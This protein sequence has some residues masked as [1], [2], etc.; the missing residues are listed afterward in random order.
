MKKALAVALLP[1]LAACT[2]GPSQAEVKG[3]VVDAST[4][5]PLAGVLVTAGRTEAKTDRRGEFVLPAVKECSEVI[6]TICSHEE[7]VVA[8]LRTIETPV[9]DLGEVELVP[10]RVEVNV[11]SNLTKKGVKARLRGPVRAT[12]RN[13]GRA[14]VLGA[15]SGDRLRVEAPGYEP[16]RVEISEDQAS[17]DV[18]LAADPGTTAGV[19]RRGLV[20]TWRRWIHRTLRHS[21]GP[22][23]G[24]SLAMVRKRQLRVPCSVAASAALIVLA[25]CKGIGPDGPSTPTS[26][27]SPST[28][29]ESPGPQP[30]EVPD[31]VGFVLADAK[32]AA[33]DV[34]MRAVVVEREFSA[35]PMGTVLDQA[36][37]AGSVAEPGAEIGVVISVFPKVPSLVGRST[38]KAKALLSALSLRAGPVV[39]RPS[40]EPKG[41]VL[42]QAI[43]A[44]RRIPAGGR[45]K[46]VAVGPHVC[47]GPLN[48]W[49]YSVAGG[50]SLIYNPSFDLCSWI[51]CISSFW[52]STN[53]Y[54][55]QCADG[56][57]SHSGGVSGSCSYH[58]GNWRPLYAP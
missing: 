40:T 2:S 58:G 27:S 51:D 9:R 31:L 48:P 34:G 56:E 30:E 1:W 42:R 46:L 29:V 39:R 49:C 38:E 25:A 52:S 11:S 4:G 15:C 13:G 10:R 19:C 41:E 16:T 37:A 18:V 17:V 55:I 45:V 32:A 28:S 8:N 47:G 5:E 57:F 20:L 6:A 22:D 7:S 26:S 54:V 23:E 24:W 35:D 43:R 44:G 33:R 12:T 36:T 3:A 14:V 53:G 50:G 21:L